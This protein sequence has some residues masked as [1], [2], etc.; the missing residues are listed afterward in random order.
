MTPSRS[1]SDAATL[2]RG[3]A[4]GFRRGGR[5]AHVTDASVTHIDV[6]VI[7]SPD[8]P[9]TD[10]PSR[11]TV[12]SIERA[13]DVLGDRGLSGLDRRGPERVVSVNVSSRRPAVVEGRSTDPGVLWVFVMDGAELEPAALAALVE[14]FDRRPDLDMAYGD[15]AARTPASTADAAPESFDRA[16]EP[17]PD[18]EFDGPWL[19]PGFSPDRL[20]DQYYLGHVVAFRPERLVSTGEETRRGTVRMP[21]IDGPWSLAPVAR[22]VAHLPVPLHSPAPSVGIRDPTR[23]G[24]RNHPGLFVGRRLPPVSVIIPTNGSSRNL[25]RGPTRLVDQAVRSV[26]ASRYPRIEIVVVETPGSPDDLIPTLVNIVDQHDSVGR[27]LTGVLDDRPFN[28][29]NACNRGAVRSAGDILVFLNDDT[30]V[31]AADW[32]TH[33]VH[34][35]QRPEVGAVGARLLY[36]DGRVQHSGIWSRGGHPTHRYEGWPGDA[37]GYRG[38]LRVTQNCLAV[39]GACLAI[40]RSKFELVGGFSPIFPNSYNDVDLC[41]KLWD[42][43]FRTVVE[44][45]AELFHFE[46]STRDPSIT[47]DDLAALHDRWRSRLNNDPFD[48]P[49]HTAERSEEWPLPA[50]VWP[51]PAGDVP[52][53]RFWPLEPIVEV[54]PS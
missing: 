24:S 45:R 17:E 5:R 41:L 19:L 46:A 43:G 49:N 18:P 26:L 15:A 14:V 16:P 34:H 53:P 30:A 8:G 9:V 3:V 52:E 11:P 51:A 42:R 12:A 23:T 37:E 7:T 44:P 4:G 48:N 29:S 1:W 40:E 10:P 47:D 20:A 2:V 36:E 33:L 13:R 50:G 32:L 6:V 27:T 22:T 35:A 31:I 39:T 28:F 25:D 21:T 54:K 38:A